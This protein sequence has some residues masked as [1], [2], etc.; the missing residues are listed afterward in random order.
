MNQNALWGVFG[1][2]V[3]GMLA[4][5]LA[6]L[7]RKAHTVKLKEALVWVAV[8]VGLAL[9]FCV[10]VYVWHKDGATKAMEFL[11]GYLLEESLSVDNIF[12][13][14]MIFSYFAVPAQYQ[15]RV[16]YWGI[17]GAI[18]MRGIFIFAGITL[19]EKFNWLIYV[20]GLFL[21]FTGIKMGIKKGETGVRPERNPVVRLFR[22][23]FPVSNHFHEERFFCKE[24]GHR[25]ATPLFVV[26]LVIETSD[27]MFALDSIPAVIG[28]TR[29]PFIVYTS[30]IFA[31]LG[32]RSLY[33]AVA[34][35][36]GLFRYLR[37]G[38]SFILAF[39]GLKMVFTEGYQ[40]FYDHDFR[41]PIEIALGV[42]FGI[43]LISVL[44]S[45]AIPEKAK[46]DSQ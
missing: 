36:M 32:L 43:L 21:I 17:L 40:S 42:V 12:V 4:L 31:I 3:G 7:D 2:I 11:T 24:A 41:F 22:R 14:I 19:I 10:G 1:L 8:W 29:D 38:L 44:A 35:I 9:A 27:V 34:G 6:L 28:V 5:D 39:I 26:L 45:L 15:H 25:L 33:F 37:I 13:F 16:L 46:S 20:F 30:N 23:F 18:V